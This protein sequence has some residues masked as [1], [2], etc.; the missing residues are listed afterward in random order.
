MI[1]IFPCQ[2]FSREPRASADRA[3][4]RLAAKQTDPP[5]PPLG[6]RMSIRSRLL[7]IFIPMTVLGPFGFAPALRAPDSGNSP[8]SNP[9]RAAVTDLLDR[10]ERVMFP[11]SRT[12][13]LG[14]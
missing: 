11:R 1:I 10:V 13:C 3:R 2:P 7:A 12:Q 8:L 14:G 9:I 6:E 4:P 5:P